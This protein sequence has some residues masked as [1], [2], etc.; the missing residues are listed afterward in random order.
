MT[1]EKANV[2]H[3]ASYEMSVS[4]LNPDLSLIP[5]E[6][7]KFMNLLSKKEADKLNVHRSYSYT[8]FLKLRKALPFS[9][10]CSIYKL[11]PVE[12]EFIR[13]YIIENPRKGFIH[14]Q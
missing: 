4:E 3:L 8:V 12:L 9:Q 14:H 6:Y 10:G 1:T 11:S 7:Y 2:A 13:T 5:P